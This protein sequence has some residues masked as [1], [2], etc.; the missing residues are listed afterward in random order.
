[1]HAHPRQTDKH[2]GN[3]VMI[4]IAHY[5]LKATQNLHQAVNFGRSEESNHKSDVSLALHCRLSCTPTYVV[6]GLIQKD[7]NNGYDITHNHNPS[8]NPLQY[9]KTSNKM[10]RKCYKKKAIN[11]VLQRALSMSC[12]MCSVI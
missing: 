7:D 4:H 8:P 12:Q 10:R 2:H 3:S 9:T 1:M 6:S 5:K 11:K